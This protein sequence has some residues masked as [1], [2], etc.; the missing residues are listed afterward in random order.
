MDIFVQ[1]KVVKLILSFSLYEVVPVYQEK[2]E[3]SRFKDTRDENEALLDLLRNGD[4]D[5]HERKI[6][7]N[8]FKDLI[9]SKGGEGIFY[10]P[11]KHLMHLSR[12]SSFYEL[13]S[14]KKSQ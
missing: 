3:N 12:S 4:K 11:D 14:L 13:H 1:Q 8:S 10:L 7:N 9:E 6:K 2:Q 5:A